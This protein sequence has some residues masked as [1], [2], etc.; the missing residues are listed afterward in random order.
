MTTC[1]IIKSVRKRT[2]KIN[3][4]PSWKSE[5]CEATTP[6]LIS[7]F[8]LASNLLQTSKDF[9]AL[10][11]EKY[12]STNQN[13]LMTVQW[14]SNSTSTTHYQALTAAVFSITAILT[15][16]DKQSTL[17]FLLSF[18]QQVFSSSVRK[19]IALSYNKF[20]TTCSDP[21]V[22]ITQKLLWKSNTNDT[23]LLAF[24]VARHTKFFVC[25]NKHKKTTAVSYWGP[26]FCLRFCDE[27]YKE[28]FLA[29]NLFRT[30]NHMSIVLRW[31]GR[32]YKFTK[33]CMFYT[34]VTSST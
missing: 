3:E 22:I 6:K 5:K 26:M 8:L 19:N 24:T 30:H 1:I 29:M 31:D 18:A 4:S 9:S 7:T 14:D 13:F 16:I 32:R 28:L 33:N 23:H 34:E 2:V 11:F 27:A 21:G 12:C 17:T 15:K 20:C 10:Y 25:E